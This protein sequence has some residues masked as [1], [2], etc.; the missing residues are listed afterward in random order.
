MLSNILKYLEQ[1][2]RAWRNSFGD[3]IS[4][5]TK[6]RIARWHFNWVDHGILR[7]LWTNF[8]AVADGVY[9]SNQPSAAR[10]R[11]YKSRGIRSILNLRGTSRYS[12]YLFEDEAC[13]TLGLDL[14]SINF[15]A[16]QLPTRQRILELENLFKTLEKPFVLHCKSGADRAGFASALYLLL[17]DGTPIDEAR[18]H[19]GLRYLHFQSS[20]KGILDYCF[21]KYSKTNDITPVS[22]RDWVMKEYDPIVLGAEFA[23]SHTARGR[24]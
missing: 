2:E 16:T 1:K 3:D 13:R 20:E 17:I 19:L 24:A 14:V 15:S 7:I 12:H 4:S 22:F 8:H 10:L 9:R 23:A 18:R 5:P 6:R 21:E 11:S